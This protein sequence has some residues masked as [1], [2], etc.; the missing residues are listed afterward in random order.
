MHLQIRLKPIL[1]LDRSY[2]HKGGTKEIISIVWKGIRNWADIITCCLR[3]DNSRSHIIYVNLNVT[4][5]YLLRPFFA[6]LKSV[7]Y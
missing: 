1:V 3:E 5:I 4:L 6:I 2:R 7:L